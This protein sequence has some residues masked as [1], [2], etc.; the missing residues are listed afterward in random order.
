VYVRG[1]RENCATLRCLV[2]ST[3]ETIETIETQT[4]EEDTANEN[5]TEE[6]NEIAYTNTSLT[7]SHGLNPLLNRCLGKK[8][9]N[10]SKKT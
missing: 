2:R 1:G 3:G 7:T 9:K 4:K 10:H 8:S 5:Q 6:G